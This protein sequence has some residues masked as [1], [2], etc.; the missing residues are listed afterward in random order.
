MKLPKSY[1]TFSDDPYIKELFDAS[2]K[3]A[4]QLTLRSGI[5]VKAIMKPVKDFVSFATVP[6]STGDDEWE[7]VFRTMGQNYDSLKEVRRAL[8]LKAF[9]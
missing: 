8:K 1:P 5:I 3:A 6:I 7:I 2:Q 4:I 9:L